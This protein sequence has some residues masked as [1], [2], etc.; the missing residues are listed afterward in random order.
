MRVL[1]TAQTDRALHEVRAKLPREIQ[2]L[3]VSVIGQSRSDMADLRTAVDNISRRADDF[4]AEESRKSIDQHVAKL[5]ELRRHRAEAYKRLI[6]IRRQEVETR[7]RARSDAQ[8]QLASRIQLTAMR[9][10][11]QVDALTDGATGRSVSSSE[12]VQW[13]RARW[14]RTSL[15][16]RTKPTADLPSCRKWFRHRTLPPGRRRAG[17]DCQ[18]GQIPDTADP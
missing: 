10:A 7:T 14:T 3:A 8:S 17:C 4:D 9:R 1:I 16:T 11:T 15:A 2:S 5:D 13:H 18:Q 6:A 12:I